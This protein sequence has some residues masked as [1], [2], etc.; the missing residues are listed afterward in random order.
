MRQAPQQVSSS[1]SRLPS[2]MP[3]VFVYA[4][5]YNGAAEWCLFSCP[6][7]S[8]PDNEPKLYLRLGSFHLTKGDFQ[9]ESN[10]TGSVSNIHYYAG[11]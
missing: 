5:R 3:K 11:M 8:P 2:C 6:L 4:H 1:L 10:D 7:K 9:E